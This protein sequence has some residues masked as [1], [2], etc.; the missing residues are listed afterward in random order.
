MASE[1]NGEYFFNCALSVVDYE[2]NIKA[3]YTN[4]YS[5]TY[6]P[7]NIK[8]LV[9]SPRIVVAQYHV[10]VGGASKGYKAVTLK[11]MLYNDVSNR[12]D[13]RPMLDILSE[14]V[15]S[16]IE[17]VVVIAT[18]ETGVQLSYKELD[19]SGMI[20]GFRGDDS[21]AQKKVFD[22]YKRLRDFCIINDPI[23][24]VDLIKTVLKHPDDGFI[25]DIK[26][27]NCNT[28]WVHKDD[29]FETIPAG[30]AR[31]YLLDL[32]GSELKNRL[33]SIK[34]SM[35]S[36]SKTAEI[37]KIKT[38]KLK[39]IIDEQNLALKS[40]RYM[41]MAQ[42]ML[43]YFIEKSPSVMLD[44]YNFNFVM[45][46]LNKVGGLSEHKSYK[47]VDTNKQ[48]SDAIKENIITLNNNMSIIY[49]NIVKFLLEGLIE[50]GNKY[51]I[52]LQTIMNGDIETTIKI[53]SSLESL[54]QR[55][56]SMTGK[57]FSGSNLKNSI[58]NACV[59]ITKL[60][61]SENTTERDKVIRYEDKA[62]WK[63]I[64]NRG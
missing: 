32:E 18:D 26:G 57:G 62:S 52:T 63:T 23:N 29:W 50:I 47:L 7:N 1:T 37:N 17:E 8:R 51:P 6:S 13:Y 35:K 58:A 4:D 25:C 20:R 60:F 24:A 12:P 11:T 46:K 56:A 61:V 10:R 42:K 64:L 43:Y 49:Y 36:A 22:R 53:P 38:S 21:D 48:D 15:C 27:L 44:K 55:I 28:I 2:G 16:S 19:I 54:N 14:R 40:Y 33:H 9:I 34:I 3:G 39:G 41:F 30:S 59:L 5:P 31:T 45:I